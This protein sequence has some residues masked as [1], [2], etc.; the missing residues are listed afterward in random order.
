MIFANFVCFFN[1]GLFHCSCGFW[2]VLWVLWV[3]VGSVGFGGFGGVWWVLE[4]SCPRQRSPWNPRNPLT[5][6]CLN[7]QSAATLPIEPI[8]LIDPID[9]SP[10]ECSVR[11][12]APFYAIEKNNHSRLAVV[13]YPLF[14]ILSGSY[15][16]CIHPL[17][18]SALLSELSF[19]MFN[20]SHC[21]Y[22]GLIQ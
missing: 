9:L 15:S 17:L 19:N 21:E 1:R 13:C 6:V 14:L 7:A 11:G 16:Y 22:I 8:E 10:P 20:I 18:D 12:N 3:L 5:S 2:W 4:S